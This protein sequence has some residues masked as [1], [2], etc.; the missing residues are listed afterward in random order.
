M[1]K[2]FW[3]ERW[4]QQQIGFHQ[5]EINQYLQKY[6]QVVSRHFP[7]SHVFVP[8]CGK[9]RDMLWLREQG[10]PV[11][12]IEFSEAAVNDFYIENALSRENSD[13]IN[14]ICGDFFQLEKDDLSTCHLVYDRAS[15]VALPVE[16]RQDYV[17]HMT[18]I[19]PDDVH[20]LLITME[21]PQ[22]EMTGPPFSVAESEVFSL[23]QPY[24]EVEKLDTFD[25]YK[26]NPRFQEK[27]LTSLV[28]KVFW[29]YR[30]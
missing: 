24:F 18:A 5:P 21:Y 15:L 10:H 29:L 26:E 30:K 8:L 17:A 14:L 2:A 27:G 20:M 25:I 13:D 1:D 6:W 12:G 11:L 9:S 4:Q 19:L 7:A 16:M 22:Q 23:Y 28:E 3:L